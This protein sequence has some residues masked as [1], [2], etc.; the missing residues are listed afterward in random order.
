MKA[1]GVGKEVRPG[2]RQKKVRRVVINAL[3]KGKKKT[4]EISAMV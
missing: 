2:T 1:S 3:R 4:G